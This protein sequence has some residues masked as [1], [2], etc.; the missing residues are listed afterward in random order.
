MK[1][2]LITSLILASSILLTQ[3]ICNE[4]ESIDPG[5]IWTKNCKK[6]HD[7]DGSGTTKIGKKFGVRNYTDPAVQASFTDEE[8]VQVT[9]EGILDE[10][11]KKKM[12]PYADKLSDAEIQA[13]I[14]LIRA[15]AGE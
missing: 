6:C 9:K 11:G 2:S 13:L 14:P 7:S 3:G 5:A 15:F 1:T 12:P 10:H 4:T 8:I